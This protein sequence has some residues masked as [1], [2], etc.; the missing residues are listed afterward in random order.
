[1]FGHQ[2]EQAFHYGFGD[3]RVLLPLLVSISPFVFWGLIAFGRL[4][5]DKFSRS[6]FTFYFLALIIGLIVFIPGVDSRVNLWLV[7]RLK[8][9]N[10]LVVNR[11]L[12]YV[13]FFALMLG[14]YG[15]NAMVKGRKLIL[16]TIIFF[17][18]FN[19]G[20]IAFP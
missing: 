2:Q 18:V 3:N 9:I 5:K 6:E 8:F 11:A 4:I 13:A 7:N 1:M 19:F 15:L 12:M 14:I 10:F 20:L 17:S 16:T